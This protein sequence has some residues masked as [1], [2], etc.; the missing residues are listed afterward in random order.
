MQSIEER[1]QE[2]EQA[3]RV[4]SF[5]IP[6][7]AWEIFLTERVKEPYKGF[8]CATGGKRVYRAGESRYENPEETAIR[9]FC[10]EEYFSTL[11]PENINP[12]TQ[13]ML[14]RLRF[15]SFHYMLHEVYEPSDFLFSQ[16]PHFSKEPPF[17]IPVPKYCRWIM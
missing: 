15:M 1:I 2:A 14:E 5:I 12:I 8:Y 9:E 7:K 4:A 10:E 6:V 13:H 17:D 16:I 11:K 3:N